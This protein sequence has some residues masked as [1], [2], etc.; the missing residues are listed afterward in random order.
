M[1]TPPGAFFRT[2]ASAGVPQPNLIPV[3]ITDGNSLR[4]H[5]LPTVGDVGGQP[6]LITLRYATGGDI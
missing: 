2:A 3:Y 5:Q 1:L 4:R 6:P